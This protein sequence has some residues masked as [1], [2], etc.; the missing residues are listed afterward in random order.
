MEDSRHRHSNQILRKSFTVIGVVL[1]LLGFYGLATITSLVRAYMAKPDAQNGGIVIMSRFVHISY[2]AALG[3]AAAAVF[4]VLVG[5]F[6]IFV[7]NRK[8]T[9]LSTSKQS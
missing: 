9:P 4:L 8:Q 3:I 5:I 1:V 7:G 2:F 6:V